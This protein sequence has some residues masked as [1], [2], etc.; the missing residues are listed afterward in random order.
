MFG[1]IVTLLLVT[2]FNVSPIRAGMECCGE[3]NVI[4][5]N[6]TCTNGKKI[7]ELACDLKISMDANQTDM[8]VDE[9]GNLVFSDYDEVVPQN[10]Y[11]ITSLQTMNG[12]RSE[13]IILCYEEEPNH[14]NFMIINVVLSL[15][16][17]IF[18]VLTIAVYLSTPELLDLQGMCLIWVISGLASSFIVLAIIDLSNHITQEFCELLAYMMYMSFMLTFFWLNVLCFHIWRVIINPKIL[19]FTKRWQLIYHIFGIAGPLTLLFIV[20]T[21][22]YS[23]LS[24]FEDVH[25]NIGEVKCWFKT[26]L[27]TFIYFYGP[28]SILLCINIVYFIW[29]IVVLWGQMKHCSEKKTKI[30]KY[31]LLLC[32]K[33][34]FVMGMT[35]CFEVFSAVFESS[36]PKWIW[37]IPDAINALQGLLV[38]LLL[39]VF[40]KRA[41]RALANKKIFRSVKLPASW[42]Y[43]QDDECEELEEE[44]SLSG[45]EKKAAQE[46][47]IFH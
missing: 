19:R 3:D 36:T 38:F 46:K 25:P 33:L 10:E 30:L 41:V 22:N 13:I 12:K 5:P 32:I 44:I 18:I 26:P 31:R 4:L 8:T 42:R 1:A 16:S 28:I 23:G 17:V 47:D 45:L 9:N 2:C 11:C 14:F 34:F 29:T 6:K 15:V 20:L 27:V 21:A 35:W 40:R 39:V 7:K 43:V 24:Y 37:V